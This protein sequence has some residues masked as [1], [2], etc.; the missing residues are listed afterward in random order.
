MATVLERTSN[1]QT[2]PLQP[3][4][5]NSLVVATRNPPSN[6]PEP[7]QNVIGQ[8]QVP[9]Q[10]VLQGRLLPEAPVQATPSMEKKRER[11]QNDNLDP[12]DL[13]FKVVYEP[14]KRADGTSEDVLVE[15][16]AFPSDEIMCG[17]LY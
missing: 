5:E 2:A 3:S 17:T 6:A 16:A 11:T 1:S 14:P 8:H 15:Y 10:Q 12:N 9:S 13:G 4:P 7:A